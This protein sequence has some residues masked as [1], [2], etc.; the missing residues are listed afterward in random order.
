LK[1]SETM[2]SFKDEFE[3]LQGVS[4]WSI[5]FLILLAAPSIAPTQARVSAASKALPVRVLYRSG[6]MS[7]RRWA[8]KPFF[9]LQG[10]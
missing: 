5:R 8:T 1:K 7:L 2:N 9:V 10:S 3:C 6:K 4:L